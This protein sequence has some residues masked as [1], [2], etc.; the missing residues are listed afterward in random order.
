LWSIH[1]KYLDAKGLVAL[2]RE[3][4]LAQKVMKGE[5]KGYRHHP[6]LKRFMANPDPQGAIASYLKD[7]WNESSLRGYDFDR[8][9]IGEVSLIDK[10]P[11]TRGQ[12]LFEFDRLCNKLKIRNF[13]KFQELISMKEIECH[14]I[15]EVIEGEIEE[16]EKL[17]KRSN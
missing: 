9:K 11:V 5:T 14:P 2:W 8:E 7:I 16:W 13:K 1:P 3:S 15:F 12:L 17:Q 10:I 4:L 6:Q